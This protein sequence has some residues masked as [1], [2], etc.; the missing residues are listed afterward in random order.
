M[1]AKR[2]S[3]GDK[4]RLTGA[5]LRSTGQY[6][7]QEAHNRWT[8]QA[9]PGCKLCADGRFILTDELRQDDDMFTAEELA[10]NPLLKYRH[11]N[12]S[13]VERCR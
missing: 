12:A 1:R 10:A 11:V 9:H 4:V 13:N 2:F 6:V 8:V 5:F 7:G 3:I